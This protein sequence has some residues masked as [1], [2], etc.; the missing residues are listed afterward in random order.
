MKP[1]TG[2]TYRIAHSRFGRS[3]VT[4]EAVDDTWADCLIVG[5]KLQG[6][7]DYWE[8]GDRKTL[9]IEHAT[10]EPVNNTNVLKRRHQGKCPLCGRFLLAD[11]HCPKTWKDGEGGREHS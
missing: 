7:N 1:K 10:W 5:A 11:G 4:V 8:A 9:C 2:G 3:I 6:M